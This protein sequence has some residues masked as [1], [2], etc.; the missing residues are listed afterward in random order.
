[1]FE[2][3]N[4]ILENMMEHPESAIEVMKKLRTMTIE[5]ERVELLET[6]HNDTISEFET[7][8]LWE[9]DPPKYD[10]SYPLQ[11]PP[12][13]AFFP[14]K[15]NKG[16]GVVIVAPGGGFNE[17]SIW[18]E[19][20]PIAQ[21]LINNGISAAILDYRLKPYTQD[22]SIGDMQ[23]AIRVLRYRADE[24]G[25][26]KNKIS[27][28]G[29]SAGGMLSSMC[30]VHFDLGHPESDDPIERES[31]RPDN[32]IVSYG[33][34][35]MIPPLKI[36]ESPLSAEG[37]KDAHYYTPFK[38]VTPDTP[39]FF[40]WQTCDQDDP[41]PMCQMITALAECGVRCEA[42]IFPFGPHGLGMANGAN[43][44]L[45]KDMH[46]AT[47]SDLAIEWLRNY[48]QY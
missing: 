40:M 31:C 15:E 30:S 46:V 42:H 2:Q 4:V 35:S 20:L 5:E 13:I 3:N 36:L 45:G 47:W 17:K 6:L 38:N 10:A 24:L 39:P 28:H 32:A 33:I 21:K 23:R 9:N 11:T 41:R 37:I 7:I 12:Q 8:K 25:I 43:S 14:A 48:Y 29:S 26:D 18:W 34:F 44:G 19:G 16:G 1:M 27:V 22:V